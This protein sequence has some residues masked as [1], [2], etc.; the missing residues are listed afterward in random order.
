MS[1]LAKKNILLNDYDDGSL[2]RTYDSSVAV[3][4]GPL[5]DGTLIIHEQL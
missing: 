2:L 4:R 5:H 1:V 3:V